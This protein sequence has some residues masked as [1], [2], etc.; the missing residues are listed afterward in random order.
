MPLH[1]FREHFHL[2]VA[3]V[4]RYIGPSTQESRLQEH[5]S[6]KSICDANP[7]ARNHANKLDAMGIVLSQ[8]KSFDG[9]KTIVRGLNVEFKSDKP[10]YEHLGGANHL[11][12]GAGKTLA[13]ATI[14]YY[15]SLEKW[16]DKKENFMLLPDPRRRHNMPFR[17]NTAEELNTHLNTCAKLE[18]RITAKKKKRVSSNG[19]S[20]TMA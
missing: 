9:K 6:I 17:I 13:D 7:N 20:G 4:W 14:N 5:R 18:N 8:F 15:D 19:L 10:G 16:L 2:F 3:P 1:K 11:G 12:Y